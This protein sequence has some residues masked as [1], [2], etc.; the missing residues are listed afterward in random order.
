MTA[1]IQLPGT[2][3]PQ[4]GMELALI[5]NEAGFIAKGLEA[6]YLLEDGSGTSAVDEAGGS[7][8]VI[9]SLVNSNNAYSWLSGGGGLSLS[10][11]QML[12]APEFDASG[13]WTLFAFGAT[14]GDVGPAGEKVVGVTGLRDFGA[15]QVRGA[16]LFIRG[17]ND[18]DVPSAAYYVQR[19]PDGSGGLGTADNLEPTFI[20]V[21]A[22]KRV[23]ALSYNGS[24]TL[25]SVIYDK[26]GAV[27][28]SSEMPAT[29]ATMF[30]ISGS[31]DAMQQPVLGGVS[32]TFA[33]GRQEFEA[34][35]RYDRFIGSFTA[36]EIKALANRAATIGAARGRP[37]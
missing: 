30:T 34:F 20:N 17:A 37:W 35:A 23:H 33:G 29:D 4:P 5:V 16:Y 10:G 24:S 2:V 31:T 12:S 22:V 1:I 7:P 6:L 3:T 25:R 11:A 32:G 8:A 15:A 9:D 18:L 14:V 21:S 19:I 28:A 13:A 27:I 36:A 26:N